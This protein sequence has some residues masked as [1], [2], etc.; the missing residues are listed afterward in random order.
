[1]VIG[2]DGAVPTL[3][4]KYMNDGV[5][6]NIEDLIENGVYYTAYPHP[7]CD[8][9]TNWTTIA[10][11]SPTGTHGATS[12]YM[13]IPGEPLDLGL[14]LRGRS[15]LAAY[16]EAEYIWEVADRINI[17]TLILNYPVGWGSR[18][19][20]GSIIVLSWPMPE[21]K[22]CNVAPPQTYIFNLKRDLKLSS[23]SNGSH[24]PP[25]RMK[26][27]IE[28]G[29]IKKPRYLEARLAKSGGDKYD[30]IAISENGRAHLIG[31]KSKSRWI[32]LKVE[33]EY[34]I[35][36][37]K[38]RVKLLHIS[39]DGSLI[40]IYR[41]EVLNVNGWTMPERLGDELIENSLI[42]VRPLVET[43][44]YVIYGKEKDTV[45][46]YVREA[47]SLVKISRYL[48]E[49]MDWRICLLH[50]HILDDL[51]HRFAA[52]HEGILKDDEA[53]AE[54][55]MKTG[56]MIVDNFVGELIKHSCDKDTLIV[57]VSDHGAVP[58]NRVLNI[59]SIFAEAGLLSYKWSWSL[60][61][62]VIDWN[63]TLAFPYVEPP[64]IWI[65]LKG[66]EPHGIVKP[67]MYEDI[68]DK[69][70]DVLYSIKDDENGR[71]PVSLALRKEDAAPLG[72]DGDRIGDVV[73]FLNP[74]YQMFDGELDQLNASKL[75][76]DLIAK[77]KIYDAER[78][79]G[80]HAY[81]LPNTKM[82][83][84]TVSAVLI[85]SGPGVKREG[86]IKKPAYLTDITPTITHLLDMPTP[87]DSSGRILYE[88]LE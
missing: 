15:Q 39:P 58:A 9:P 10:T 28:G 40:K 13:H 60:K 5:L 76:P 36:E 85:I 70:I 6:P 21:C 27:P 65:N 44:P 31:V 80:A 3:L 19:S 67:S 74:P 22:P 73:F 7:P 83:L 1:M 71:R 49:K 8:T 63:R 16:C 82:G 88:S 37:C 29:L 11:G 2:L 56:Y 38:F 75:S 64:F 79:F 35:L 18:L 51:N 32:S 69:V 48:R 81:Y 34:G 17:P 50:F 87:R 20:R 45:L 23:R 46:A 78:V 24:S 14:A 33:T 53:T 41:S 61:S 68:R 84:Y 57:L 54:E 26:I 86:K 59:A 62:Y 30:S 52:F 4:E 47:Q 43:I 77:G 12:F 66:R 42:D 72:L 25:L 55:A